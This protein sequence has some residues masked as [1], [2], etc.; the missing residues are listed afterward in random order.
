MYDTNVCDN[1]GRNLYLINKFIH[2][3][4]KQHEDKILEK[5]ITLDL[6]KVFSELHLDMCCRSVILCRL[7]ITSDVLCYPSISKS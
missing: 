3:I 2:E 5:N 1:C 7:D 6:P 4:K